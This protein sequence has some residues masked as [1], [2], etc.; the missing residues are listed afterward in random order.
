MSWRPTEYDDV[1]WAGPFADREAALAALDRGI[2]RA[3]YQRD[4]DDGELTDV[5]LARAAGSWGMGVPASLLFGPTRF[6]AFLDFDP[7][8]EWGP[9]IGYSIFPVEDRDDAPHQGPALRSE[10]QS[11]HPD[12]GAW[13]AALA[14]IARRARAPVDEEDFDE[15]GILFP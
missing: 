15:A 9:P 8:N 11:M 5:A 10:K 1:G 2:E 7:D 3:G 6:V 14:E 4:D 13:D 12:N